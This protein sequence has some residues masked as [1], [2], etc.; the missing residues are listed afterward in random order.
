MIQVQTYY[1]RW[2]VGT[3]EEL[4]EGSKAYTLDPSQIKVPM[5]NIIGENEYNQGISSRQWIEETINKAPILVENVITP[6]NEGT[7]S[8][9]MGANRSLMSQIVFDWLDEQLG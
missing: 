9:C 8:H 3:V 7:D 2:G 6:T 4:V 1:W 5:L